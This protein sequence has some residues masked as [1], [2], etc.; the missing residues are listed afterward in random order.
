MLYEDYGASTR[1]ALDGTLG[2]LLDLLRKY[3]AQKDPT[4]YFM[5][6]VKRAFHSSPADRKIIGRTMAFTSFVHR[7]QKRKTGEPY[8]IHPISA[9]AII[10]EHL[11][12]KD[13]IAIAGALGHDIDEDHAILAY[14]SFLFQIDPR[15]TAIIEGCNRN[16]FAKIKD[17]QKQ[18]DAFLGAI[19]TGESEIIRLVKSAEKLHNNCTPDPHSL[20]QPSWRARKARTIHTWYEPMT[21]AIDQLKEEMVA[22]RIAIEHGI[23]LI[24]MP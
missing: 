20:L 16:G 24:D 19:L 23:R 6:W 13:S 17:K 11:D 1:D 7:R 4:Q 3:A 14:A 10:G 21:Q 5:S 15:V 8:I 2:H 22:S 9:G 18:D 12:I